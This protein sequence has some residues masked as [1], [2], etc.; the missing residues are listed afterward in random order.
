[1][2]Y[3]IKHLGSVSG[4]KMIQFELVIRTIW[5][6]YLFFNDLTIKYRFI[7]PIDIIWWLRYGRG[8]SRNYISINSLLTVHGKCDKKIQQKL[9][10]LYT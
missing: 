1:M 10:D 8:K 4:G 5:I 2:A 9:I 6:V 7:V 3:D